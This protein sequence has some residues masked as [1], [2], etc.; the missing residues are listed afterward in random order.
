M[1]EIVKCY[2]HASFPRAESLE[3]IKL[4][5]L[6]FSI[7]KMGNE[8]HLIEP[9]WDLNVVRKMT[10]SAPETRRQI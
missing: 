5:S 2:L 9:L 1:L 7:Y 4:L 3:Q 6:N 8:D 10:K